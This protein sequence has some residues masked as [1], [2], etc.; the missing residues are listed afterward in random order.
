[1]SVIPDQQESHRRILK[2]IKAFILV[3]MTLWSCKVF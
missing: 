3:F 2:L 1:M